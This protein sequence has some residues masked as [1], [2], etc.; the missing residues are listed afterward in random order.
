LSLYIFKVPLDALS[1][2]DSIAPINLG[3]SSEA[4]PDR[5][6]LTL[7]VVIPIDLVRECGTRPNK[8]HLAPKNIEK[9]REFI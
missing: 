2:R 3:E 1:P 8:A 6:S 5:Q 9:L 4:R 7:M